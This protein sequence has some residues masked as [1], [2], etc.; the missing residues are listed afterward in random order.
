MVHAVAIWIFLDYVLWNLDRVGTIFAVIPAFVECFVLL[1]AV[2]RIEE[3][4]TGK[5]EVVNLV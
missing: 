5:H 3:R 2:K 1:I 4:L